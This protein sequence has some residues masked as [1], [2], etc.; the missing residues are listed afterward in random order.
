M[1]Y[2][3]PNDYWHG[4][5]PYKGMSDDERMKAGCLH[6]AALIIAAIVALLLCSMLSSCKSQEHIVTIETVRADTTYIT[7][8]ERDSIHVHDSTHVSEK[9]RGDTIFVEVSRWRTKYM[10]RQVHDTCYVATHDTVPQPYPVEVEVPAPISWWQRLRMQLGGA[11]LLLL[12]S[13]VV[14]I[15]VRAR[16]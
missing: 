14:W 2:N 10:E 5:D 8:H 7:R 12:A 6:G 13:G 15:L 4:Y 1:D 16:I 3:N 9:Q 11:L